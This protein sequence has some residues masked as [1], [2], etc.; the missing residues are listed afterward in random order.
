MRKLHNQN[1]S[2]LVFLLLGTLLAQSGHAAEPPAT[3][4]QPE[5]L[6]LGVLP[7]MSPIALVKRFS[8]LVKYLEEKTGQP[9]R[10]LSAA[11]Y[12]EF[13]KR[14]EE[15][16]YDI[17]ITAPHF[18]LMALD[19]GK[20]EV[21]A[22]YLKPL[23][24]HLVVHRES[25]LRETYQ[26]AG[27]VIALPPPEAIITTIGR[28][29]LN[30]RGLG[31]E[32]VPLYKNYGSHN[33]AYQAVVANEASAAIISVNVLRGA[34]Q[35]GAPIIP[36]A[37]SEDYPGLGILTSR[38]MSVEQ[39]QKIVQTLVQMRN[40][41]AG[42]SV[43]KQISYPGYRPATASEFETLRK[44]MQPARQNPHSSTVTKP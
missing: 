7:F 34:I 13:I 14:T 44:Y 37:K 11:N 29:M 2:M 36:I 24:A 6:R 30:Q 9:I 38:R 19:S 1:K 22:A 16:R 33:A 25:K 20:Y 32:K 15:G 5:R 35:K 28:E 10:L 39:Q 31:G 4:Q 43:L 27:K 3:R 12:P 42:R 18:V 21:H 40:H 26:L 23:S 41:P 8:P 17:V